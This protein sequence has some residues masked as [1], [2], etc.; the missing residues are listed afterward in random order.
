MNCCSLF[1]LRREQKVAFACRHLLSCRQSCSKQVL[2]RKKSSRSRR[3]V[4]KAGPVSFGLRHLVVGIRFR[5]CRLLQIGVDAL[6][7]GGNRV[8]VSA[9]NSHSLARVA[10]SSLPREMRRQG[11][12][13]GSRSA[14]VNRGCGSKLNRD[15]AGVGYVWSM[16]P[17]TRVPFW[18]R[19]LEPQPCICLF[20][21]LA[22]GNIL[23]LG[24]PYIV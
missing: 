10:R 20:Y 11:E 4:C 14:R 2:S 19:F 15:Y 16:F 22:M 12:A 9:R 24:I 1:R 17:F 23:S 6:L 3:I 13:Q 18:Y 5:W 8:S 7:R 21:S